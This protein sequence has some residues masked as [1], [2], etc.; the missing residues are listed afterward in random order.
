M[1]F[2]ATAF[3][4][5]SGQVT[6]SAILIAIG[7][8][9]LAALVVAY[10]A[11]ERIANMPEGTI[12]PSPARTAALLTCV[13][14][15]GLMAAG[16]AEG[17]GS[18]NPDTWHTRIPGWASAAIWGVPAAMALWTL[19]TRRGAWATVA[20]LVIGPVVRVLSYGWAWVIYLTADEGR[21]SEGGY[22]YAGLHL[23]MVGIVITT[24]YLTREDRAVRGGP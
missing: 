9:A 20:L 3:T 7:V 5:V 24:A 23:A 6:A 21:G 11:D 18:T 8:A 1:N 19:I 14:V 10:F 13:F 4:S 2:L 22:Y 16:V 17:L 15:W 12:T